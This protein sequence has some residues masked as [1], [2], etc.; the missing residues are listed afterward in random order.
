MYT[1]R[2]GKDDA[3]SCVEVHPD[4]ERELTVRGGRVETTVATH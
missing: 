3:L 1:L 2:E 4:I